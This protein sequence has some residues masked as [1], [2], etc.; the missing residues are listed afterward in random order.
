MPE[1][2]SF[3]SI[4]LKDERILLVGG[5]GFIGHHL[6]LGCREKGAEVMVV[7]NL[8]VNNLVKIV[9]DPEL[10][11]LRRQLY[12]EFVLDRFFA[13]REANVKIRT[14]DARQMAD[15]SECFREFL[16]TKVVHLAA[17]SSAV[18]ANQQSNLAYDLQ[19]TT[20]RNT[21][22]LCRLQKPTCNRIVFMS[23][24]TVYG[25]FETDSVNESV[26]PNPRGVYA[27]A[28][29]IGERMVRSE[30]ELYGL[31]Y[32]IVRPSA[33]YGERCISGRVSQ[34]FIENA[35]A[36][37]PLYLEGGGDGKLDFTHVGDLVEGI[38]RALA[39]PGGIGTFNITYGQARTIRDL[40]DIIKK[41]V[42]DVKLE[43]RPPAPEKPKRGTLIMDKARDRLG[44]I[45]SRSLDEAYEKYC[46]W[47][48]E[49]WEKLAS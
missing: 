41:I 46:R 30:R 4:S 22:E 3:D 21:L 1:P 7:D 48:Q 34:K 25:D 39:L 38:V 31:D 17:I 2:I 26:R 19:I 16:P 13:L 33:L 49:K 10:D 24:S 15:L 37:K 44:F 11:P 43:E 8:Q 42:P 9:T 5:A 40:A 20:L 14:V 47:Y 45:P 28:K 12:T 29:Y 23:S 18:I 32:T 6:A 27:N 35:L 36:G